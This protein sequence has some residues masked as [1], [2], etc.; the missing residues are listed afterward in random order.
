MHTVKKFYLGDKD[1]AG[2][3]ITPGWAVI[4]ETG[5]V[6][7]NDI[8]TFKSSA[9]SQARWLNEKSAVLKAYRT[10][11]KSKEHSPYPARAWMHFA[12]TLESASA[13]AE[14]RIKEEFSGRGVVVSTEETTDPRNIAERKGD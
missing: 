14:R 7:G 2:K 13:Y 12:P 5:A 1:T 3:T 6:V 10:T 11:F 4:D 9:E 8:F